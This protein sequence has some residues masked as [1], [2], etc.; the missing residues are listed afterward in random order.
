MTAEPDST[1]AL[2]TAAADLFFSLS[3]ILILLVCLLSQSL[4]SLVA[5]HNDPTPALHAAASQSG[6]WLVT[7]DARGVTLSRPDRPVETVP[8]DA[9][10]ATPLAEWSTTTPRVVILPDA[11]DSAFLLDTALSRAGVAHTARIRLGGPCPAP[12]FTATGLACNG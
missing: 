3:A 5:R 12:R 1:P 7:A 8:T 11:T 9:I 2:G 6:L 10:L 4:H